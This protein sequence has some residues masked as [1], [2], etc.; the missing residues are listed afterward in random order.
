MAGAA[1]EAVARAAAG[2]TFTRVAIP[3][4]HVEAKGSYNAIGRQV[5]EA[6]RE[7]IGA[8]ISFYEEHFVAMSGLS[9]A[10]AE[11]Q[12][13]AYLPYAQRYLPQY[14]AELEG[15]AQ[16]A[17]QPFAK[18]LV[19]NCAEEFTCPT[20]GQ[21]AAGRLCT[22]VAVSS[23]GRHVVGHNM[24]WYV[25]DV[26][27]NVLFDLTFDDGTRA[28]TIAGVPYLPILGMSSHGLAYVGNSV[29]SNDS[30]LGVPNAFVRRWTLESRTLEEA[31]ER[32]TMASRARGSN[33]TFGDA[34][35][36]LWDIETSAGAH[37]LMTGDGWLAHT[38]H[39][40][41]P[42]MQRFEG[43]DH[44][45]SRRRLAVAERLLSQG[46]ERGDDALELVMRVLRDHTGAPDSI[47]GHEDASAPIAERVITV[48]SMVCDL[49]EGRLH[50]CAGPPCEN[51]YRVFTL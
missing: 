48:A 33:H 27:K 16:G 36:R 40:I 28:L 12:A 21:R 35:G 37:A 7:I 17:N 38:N 11:R 31:S 2:L 26:D 44:I 1:R 22:A 49:D 14:V 23:G 9:F 39:Y 50:A 45:E 34:G 46:V 10:D 5:G 24:D 43:Y 32:A 47:C 3:F 15:T 20:D 42:S 29:Y 18:L 13:Q 30:R 4:L 19:P 25:V 6:A 8:A 41:E 51:E